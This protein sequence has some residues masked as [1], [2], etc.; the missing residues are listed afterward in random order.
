MDNETVR[1]ETRGE[2]T[3]PY[4]CTPKDKHMRN[5]WSV[6]TDD[7][8]YRD[9]VD[10][11]G[12]YVATNI[13]KDYSDGFLSELISFVNTYID[14]SESYPSLQT[15]FDKIAE[16]K[17]DHWDYGLYMDIYYFLNPDLYEKWQMLEE[18]KDFR[19]KVHFG[20]NAVLLLETSM[21]LTRNKI[22]PRIGDEFMV[23]DEGNERLLMRFVPPEKHEVNTNGF[24]LRSVDFSTEDNCIYLY[25]NYYLRSEFDKKQNR[26]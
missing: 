26:H 8:G 20:G 16:A 6:T 22:I 24:V 7:E 23:A 21:F 15:L 17:V 25:A 5:K 9:I 11:E 13:R 19:I 18:T 12:L 2:K 4:F 1:K 10:T 3:L 14:K